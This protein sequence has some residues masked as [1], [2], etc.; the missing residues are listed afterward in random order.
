MRRSTRK[1][2]HIVPALL[3]ILNVGCSRTFFRQAADKDVEGVI[4][5]KNKFPDWD[6]KSW[7]VYPDPRSR[8]ADASNPDR[9]PYPP[10]DYAARVLSPNPQHPTNRTGTGRVDGDGYLKMLEEWNA[11]NRADD[12]ANARGVPPDSLS[13]MILYKSETT[14]QATLPNPTGSGV[15]GSAT[16]ASPSVSE[17]SPWMS[18]RSAISTPARTRIKTFLSARHRISG[19]DRD[20]C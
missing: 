8:F 16:V 13:G 6:T 7:H 20:S 18:A 1:K 9:P 3:M 17:P 19:L 14:D 11:K 15:A 5:E 2:L 4:T 12:P 10:D